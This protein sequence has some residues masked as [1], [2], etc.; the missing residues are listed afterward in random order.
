MDLFSALGPAVGA[1]MAHRRESVTRYYFLS[2][3]AAQEL[4]AALANAPE[5]SGCGHVVAL[6]DERT[7]AAAGQVCMSALRERGFTVTLRVLPDTHP[8]SPSVSM[9]TAEGPVCDDITH[10]RLLDELG[11]LRPDLL[12]GIGSGVISDL[13]KWVAFDLGV[14]SAI[15]ATAAS[16]NGYTAANVAPAIAGVKTL[17]AARS[18][19]A[20]AADPRVLAEAPMALTSAGLGDV[21]A[22]WVSTADWRMNEVLFGE[23]Y[24]PPIA[25]ILDHVEKTY[26]SRPEGIKDRE[27]EAIAALFSALVFSGCAM[28]LQGSSMPASGGEHLIS[29]ALDMRAMA[30]GGG[31]D[32]H[33]RQVGVGTIVA[34][35]LYQQIFASA[36][37][38]LRV[39]ALILDHQGWG[40]AA[41]AVAQHFKG[42]CAR[43]EEAVAQLQARGAW[44]TLREALA[45]LLPD[46]TRI[47]RVLS[48]AGAAHRVEQLRGVDRERF[49]WAVLNGSH[50][51]ERFT[52]LDLAWVTGVLPHQLDPL[53][54]RYGVTA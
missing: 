32:L 20:V 35:A 31:H 3:D 5:L 7:L 22:K 11:S 8:G 30:E 13:S 53:L 2:P 1:A 25:G 14:R 40:S 26:L 4:A 12:L 49:R 54:A 21:I 37:P 28:T 46:P 6:A 33:G 42:K 48:A 16:M 44:D 36:E 51:R 34:A 41:S 39:P 38:E 17:I 29:H 45:P 52:S 24:L 27:P 9:M 47:Q 50:M 43:I 15:Y 19:L 10:D 18:H 23:A